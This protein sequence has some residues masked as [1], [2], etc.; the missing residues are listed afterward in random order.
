[1]TN[2]ATIDKRAEQYVA[3]RDAIRKIEE[4]HEQELKS[5]KST[6]S[7]LS[8]EMLEFIEQTG[9]TSIRT[10]HG[11]VG[12]SL[13]HNASLADPDAFM[14]HVIGTES[15]DLIERRA[16]ATACWDFVKGNNGVAPPGVNLSTL[17][18]LS[19][20]RPTTKEE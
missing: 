8:G 16:N 13:R 4:R 20:R 12:V 10:P 5:W 9:A 17:K 6:L 14:R 1:M 18:T 19:V 15:W 3:I 7:K 2:G 11:T